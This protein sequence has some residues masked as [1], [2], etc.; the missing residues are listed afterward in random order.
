M[1]SA[2]ATAAMV[3][4]EAVAA[5]ADAVAAV[6]SLTTGEDIGRALLEL[7]EEEEDEDCVGGRCAKTP[8]TIGRTAPRRWNLVQPGTPHFSGASRGGSVDSFHC[9][10]NTQFRLSVIGSTSNELRSGRVE[11]RGTPLG[12]YSSL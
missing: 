10:N 3:A 2:A 7:E 11:P 6:A 8:G 1:R 12:A 5:T 4:V 9:Q